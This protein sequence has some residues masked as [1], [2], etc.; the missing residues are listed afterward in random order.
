MQTY[1]ELTLTFHISA[2]KMSVRDDDPFCSCKAG[3]VCYQ[4]YCLPFHLSALCAVLRFSHQ[5]PS[6]VPLWPFKTNLRKGF[7]ETN[8]TAV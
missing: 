7:Y 5:C 6:L 3:Q 2:R 4:F 1:L 8:S